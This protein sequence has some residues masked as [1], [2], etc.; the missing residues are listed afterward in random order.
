MQVLTALKE[1]IPR[2]H[3]ENVKQHRYVRTCEQE[4]IAKVT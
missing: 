4:W 2:Q 3:L 1:Q